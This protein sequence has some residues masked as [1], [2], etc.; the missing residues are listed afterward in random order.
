LVPKETGRKESISFISS[1]FQSLMV[2][3]ENRSLFHYRSN[4][5]SCKAS[6][7]KVFK[8]LGISDLQKTF[9]G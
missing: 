1:L 2:Q 3:V 8:F 7:M 5:F 9:G 4:G 6:L